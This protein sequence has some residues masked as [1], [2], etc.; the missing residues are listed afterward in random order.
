MLHPLHLPGTLFTGC[1]LH[2]RMVS[3]QIILNSLPETLSPVAVTS[4]VQSWFCHSTQQVLTK[5]KQCDLGSRDSL[6]TTQKPKKL[7]KC[8][9]LT[10][11]GWQNRDKGQC[12]SARPLLDEEAHGPSLGSWGRTGKRTFLE[13]TSCTGGLIL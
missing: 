3:S 11:L 12:S 13:K 1:H 7:L 9:A 6:V 4:P 5:I 2:T 8:P 10:T